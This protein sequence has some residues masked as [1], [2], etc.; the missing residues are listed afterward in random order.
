MRGLI[1]RLK[2]NVCVRKWE[3]N[4]LSGLSKIEATAW[5]CL[6]I[7]IVCMLCLGWVVHASVG[8]G[9]DSALFAAIERQNVQA[10]V[11]AIN[12]GANVNAKDD[13]EYGY[14]PVMHAAWKGNIV[15]AKLLIQKGA[16]PC[17]ATGNDYTV[18]MSAA[19]SG[20]FE[21]VK[22]LGSLGCDMMGEA[23]FRHGYYTNAL[24]EA[25]STG[26]RQLIEFLVEKGLNPNDQRFC[27]RYLSEV[28]KSGNQ[29]AIQFLLT[30][31][32]D[33]EC[34][35]GAL[36]ESI[37]TKNKNLTNVL[38]S[39]GASVNHIENNSHGTACV[40]A[41]PL[42]SAIESRDESLAEVLVSKGANPNLPDCGDA[43]D[44]SAFKITVAQGNRNL[45]T[46]LLSHG[47]DA[48]GVLP[49]A[50][51]V[52]MAELLLTH[53]ADINYALKGD[54]TALMSAARA[55]QKKLVEYLIAR[56]ADV[57]WKMDREAWFPA[58]W[59]PP[60]ALRMAQENHHDDIVAILKKAGARE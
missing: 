6:R 41:T 12:S 34:L 47:A 42:S 57:N 59:K 24:G 17:Y 18:A 44:A 49:W 9:Q 37:R 32:T 3:I 11:E 56:G 51:D 60:T 48:K 55:G 45:V 30:R 58:D 16:N 22:Y 39:R 7:I 10:V 8:P 19:R 23:H 4:H 52:E 46:L 43:G 31:S 21:L 35:G 36:V 28:T 40:E 13:D 14:S 53:G 2:P 20:N 25:A 29:D 1:A 26:N 50:D 54:F 15:L 33:T 38:L 27:S 5:G